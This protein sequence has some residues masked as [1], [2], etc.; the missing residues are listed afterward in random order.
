MGDGAIYFEMIAPQGEIKGLE[1][2]GA[3]IGEWGGIN[4]KNA[5]QFR[6]LSVFLR[7]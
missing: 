3:D 1:D 7:A 2:Q 5:R 6:V 4:R